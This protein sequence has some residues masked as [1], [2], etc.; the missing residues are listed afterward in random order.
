M[1]VL[2]MLL[3]FRKETEEIYLSL[4]NRKEVT[5]TQIKNSALKHIF[6]NMYM[7]ITEVRRIYKFRSLF[8]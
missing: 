8:I 7:H 5:K 1:F 6:F 2:L 3:K 4:E